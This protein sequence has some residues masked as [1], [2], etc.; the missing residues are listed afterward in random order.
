[1]GM[2]HRHELKKNK[3]YTL[4]IYYQREK[5]GRVASLKVMEALV[6]RERELKAV[7]VGL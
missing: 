5:W 1:M 6:I 3:Q 4:A 7:F 2:K